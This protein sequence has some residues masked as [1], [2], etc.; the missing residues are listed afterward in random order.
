[1]PRRF[2]LLILAAATMV[3][4]GVCSGAG[5]IS[6]AQP[7]SAWL[8]YGGNAQV[9][10]DADGAV[11]RRPAAMRRL[12]RTKL[13]GSV[14]ASP[15]VASDIVVRGRRRSVVFVV[16]QGGFAYGLDAR[17]GATL[18][19]RAF[20]TYDTKVCGVFGTAGTPVVD[21]TG[22]RLYLVSAD[23]LLRA[24]DTSHGRRQ[25]R[26][27]PLQVVPNPRLQYAWSGLR[28][29]G[30]TLYVPR[31]RT[32]TNGTRTT[33]RPTALCARSTSEVG[34]SSPPWTPFP[35]AEPRRHLG[36]GWSLRGAERPLRSTPPS[37]TPVRATTRR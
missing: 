6:R 36:L 13:S 26:A 15:L 34:A 20:P 32:A 7:P 27:P 23:G 3:A 28:L 12:W 21:P 16:T 4:T 30:P 22:Q 25:P 24:L 8:A 5:S 17:T 33:D 11:A 9:T 37:A 18:W 10:N 31:R 19:S 1:M 35:P 29:L 14:I 2:S